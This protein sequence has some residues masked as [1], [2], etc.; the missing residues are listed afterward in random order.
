MSLNQQDV[1]D[2]PHCGKQI[3]ISAALSHTVEERILR[4]HEAKFAL[5]RR[6]LAEDEARLKATNDELAARRAGLEA[7]VAKITEKKI[8]EEREKIEKEAK[9]RV[10]AETAAQIASMKA[11]LEAN[12]AQLREL[13]QAKAALERATRE[14][15]QLKIDLEAENERRMTEFI[16]TERERIQRAETE[17]H[18][19]K[20]KDQAVLIDELKRQL[21]EAQR[22]IAQ[23]SMQRQGE[24][25]ELAIEAWLREQFPLDSV[26]EIRKGATGADCVQIV[27]TRERAN[28]GTII[29]ESKRTKAFQPAW[30]EKFKSDMRD[31][32]A[33]IGVLVTEVLPSEME[34]LGLRDGV[35]ICTF[36]EFKG[37]SAVLRETIVRLSL[38]AETQRNRGTKTEMVYDFLTGTEFRQ[39]VEGMLEGITQ[40]YTDLES[41]K[42]AFAAQWKK[43][44]KQIEKVIL[45]A[46][47]MYSSIRGIVGNAVAPI[48]Y[49][50]FE[51]GALEGGG[52]GS[53]R[54]ALEAEQPADDKQQRESDEQSLF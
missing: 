2:C 11:E 53:A 46:S 22:K 43:R 3:D 26:E 23:G 39:Q 44:E 38:V 1:I 20:V 5:E 18:E 7:E 16:R 25:Q 13:G 40:M 45:N 4:E 30:I 15:E 29:Y 12:A 50:E 48:S 9:E 14:K 8:R 47:N 6:K 24:A 34:R 52:T 51:G 21:D 37:L 32:A 49:L 10:S 41:E 28:C 54:A 17:K 33:D 35:W 19:L 36:E 31:R 42:R 27:N